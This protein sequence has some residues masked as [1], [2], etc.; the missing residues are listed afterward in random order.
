M[1]EALQLC[2]EVVLHGAVAI[3]AGA[4]LTV[5]WLR[6]A[7]SGWALAR[8]AAAPG[9]AGAAIVG[10]LLAQIA[11]LW[12]QA[13]A[14]ADVPLAD[15]APAIRTVLTDT[16][17]GVA[18]LLG[19]C[20]LLVA[21]AAGLVA[22]RPRR[23]AAL[24]LLLLSLFLYTR[25]MVSHAAATDALPALLADWLHRLLVSVWA[26]GVFVTALAAV[27]GPAAGVDGFADLVRFNRSLSRAATLALAGIVAT[28]LFA[29]WRQLGTLGNASGN[30]YATLLL[31]KIALV[32]TAAALGGANRWLIMPAFD[33]VDASHAQRAT[34]RFVWVVR[35]EAIVLLVVLIVAAM[36][37][38]TAPPAATS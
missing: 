22:R 4:M 28:G 8:R 5:F 19:A 37:G 26:G 7:A 32:V 6:H 21:A 12:L 13:A 17:Y 24:T 1:L 9:W 35:V 38:S 15:A 10:A 23:R 34:T 14:M 30:P 11:V 29:A 36:L 31:A 25:S 16:R 27:P 18:W 3:A 20:A 33:A 2:A